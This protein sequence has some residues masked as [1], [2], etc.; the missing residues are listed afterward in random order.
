MPTTPFLPLPGDLE[1]IGIHTI[2]RFS[3]S[4][5]AHDVFA[6]AVLRK[7]LLL[8]QAFSGTALYRVKIMREKV[9]LSASQLP[10]K[11]LRRTR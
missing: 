10:T 8:A 5:V 7:R 6:R 1:V 3:S 4:Y 9:L 2:G 11:S